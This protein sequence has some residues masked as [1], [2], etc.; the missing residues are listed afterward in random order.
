MRSEQRKC[1]KRMGE[2]QKEGVK[3]ELDFVQGRITK[4]SNLQAKR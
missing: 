1:Y 4:I 3:Y 2:E